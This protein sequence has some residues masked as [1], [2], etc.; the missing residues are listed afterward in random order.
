MSANADINTIFASLIK[1]HPEN[2]L[3][4]LFCK[5]N[6]Y[7]ALGWEDAEDETEKEIGRVKEGKQ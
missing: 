1:K 4:I 7:I 5:R 2:E 3:D 6:V